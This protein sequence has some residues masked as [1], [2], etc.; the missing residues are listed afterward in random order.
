VSAKGQIVI[1]KAVRE[2]LRWAAGMSLEVVEIAG[3]VV[4]K[5]RRAEQ[6]RITVEEFERR[7]PP[8]RGPPVS[9]EDMERAILDQAARRYRDRI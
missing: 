6:E 8:Y 9:I 7:H 3:G 5:P 1:P 2:R 4:L